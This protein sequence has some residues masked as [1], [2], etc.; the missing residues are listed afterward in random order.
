[1][2]LVGL[3]DL[4]P[5]PPKSVRHKHGGFTVARRWDKDPW[6]YRQ[7]MDFHSWYEPGYSCCILHQYGLRVANAAW[8][9]LR[10]ARLWPFLSK[11]W[12]VVIELFFCAMRS[13]PCIDFRISCDWIPKMCFRFFNPTSNKLYGLQPH[14]YLV[15]SSFQ[16][17]RLAQKLVAWSLIRILRFACSL[18]VS[19]R[20]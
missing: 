2:I 16:Y 4:F 10:P 11:A 14:V 15:F 18:H 9:C 13:A 3:S 20:T 19:P 12:D 6:T 1:M 17:A 5:I 8:I 7:Y